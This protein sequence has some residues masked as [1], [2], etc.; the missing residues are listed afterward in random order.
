MDC[1]YFLIYPRTWQLIHICVIFQN[2]GI[3]FEGVC[4]NIQWYCVYPGSECMG[5][6]PVASETLHFER[7]DGSGYAALIMRFY[8]GV[9]W[10]IWQ[11]TIVVTSVTLW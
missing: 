10:N 5:S 4:V 6:A 2:R 11:K 3:A 8:T 7:A 9:E 1:S